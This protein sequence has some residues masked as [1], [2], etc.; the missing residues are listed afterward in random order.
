MLNKSVPYDDY[1]TYC[2]ADL[3]AIMWIESRYDCSAVGDGGNSLGC[4]Q[5]YSVA[6]PHI[7]DDE[8]LDLRWSA[9]WTLNRLIAYGWVPRTMNG[10]ANRAAIQCHNGC[11]VE[12]GY[13]QSVVEKSNSFLN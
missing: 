9:A 7:K 6:H 3:L 5:I 2:V 4:F 13:Y 8:R 10:Q 1:I 12:N 11:G